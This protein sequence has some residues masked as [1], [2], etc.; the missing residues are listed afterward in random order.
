LLISVHKS[1]RNA[2]S[3]L[4]SIHLN[5]NHFDQDVKDYIIEKMKVE[6]GDYEKLLAPG[7]GPRRHALAEAESGPERRLQ[8]QGH[9]FF[10]AAVP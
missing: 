10:K 4:V 5:E 1:S 9:Q 2:T 8:A 7:A 6:T 3:N